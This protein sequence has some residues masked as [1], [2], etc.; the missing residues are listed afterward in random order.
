MKHL[1][2]DYY[3]DCDRY[4]Y[5]LV[6][7]RV[8]KKGENKDKEK[9]DFIAWYS[10]PHHMAEKIADIGIGEWING[11]FKDCIKFT[12][13]ALSNFLKALEDINEKAN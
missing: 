5:S 8:I 10:S 3:I 11:E 7:R 6:K 2:G 1:S 4:S 12:T 9:F 13:E